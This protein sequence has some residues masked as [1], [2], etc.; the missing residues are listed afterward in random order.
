MSVLIGRGKP[1]EIVIG[2]APDW[3]TAFAIMKKERHDINIQAPQKAMMHDM[4]SIMQPELTRR[5]QQAQQNR[6]GGARWGPCRA[7]GAR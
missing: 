4:Q 3:E 6:D 5:R 1:A 2:L 7:G